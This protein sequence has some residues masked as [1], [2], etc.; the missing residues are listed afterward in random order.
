MKMGFEMAERGLE[1]AGMDGDYD[2]RTRNKNKLL[3]CTLL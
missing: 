2:L 3:C 1:K